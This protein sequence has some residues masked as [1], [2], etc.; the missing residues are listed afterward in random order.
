M[1]TIKAMW[2]ITLNGWEWSVLVV[3]KIFKKQYL[4]NKRD[5]GSCKPWE[6]KEVA[7]AW[8]NGRG[9]AATYYQSADQLQTGRA[10]KIR[11]ASRALLN[12]LLGTDAYCSRVDSGFLSL[13]R[14]LSPYFLISNNN[15]RAMAG[16]SAEQELQ[17]L[18]KR[19]DC[20]TV[21]WKIHLELLEGVW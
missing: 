17:V 15:Q 12:F 11:P 7:P 4:F 20:L 3:G 14:S 5:W 6:M 9:R 2:Y 8:L 19:E 18:Y 21:D 1:P 16:Y 10:K 13:S